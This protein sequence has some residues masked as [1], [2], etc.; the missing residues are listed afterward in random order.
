M[1]VVVFICGHG[2]NC[3]CWWLYLVAVDVY[4]GDGRLCG[5]GIHNIIYIYIYTPLPWQWAG[6]RCVIFAIYTRL[7]DGLTDILAKGYLAA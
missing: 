7:S 6:Y 1:V 2:G 4:G 3:M 5:S